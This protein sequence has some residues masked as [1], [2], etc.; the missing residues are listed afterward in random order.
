MAVPQMHPESLLYEQKRG[1][2]RKG[3]GYRSRIKE[4]GTDNS[5]GEERR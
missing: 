5:V 4:R 1:E 3:K 2:E